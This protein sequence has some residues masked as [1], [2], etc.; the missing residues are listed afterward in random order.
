MTSKDQS[1]PKTNEQEILQEKL[2]CRCQ[3]ELKEGMKFCPH[4]GR[5]AP[6]P[7]RPP[8][9]VALESKLA[10]SLTEAGYVLSVS[11][12]TVRN[13]VSREKLRYLTIGK[14]IV[15]TRDALL[16]FIANNES[17]IPLPVERDIEGRPIREPAPYRAK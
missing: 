1:T 3:N 9:K 14:R 12:T 11:A 10:F 17:K 5:R 8:L 15:I 13:L 2:I 16:E 7:K 4:C 6:R